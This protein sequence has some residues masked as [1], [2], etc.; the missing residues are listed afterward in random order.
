MNT[1][2]IGAAIIVVARHFDIPRSS[3][4]DHLEMRT[5]SR[6]RG[7]ATV[8]NNNEEWA[9]ESYMLSMVEYG[10]PLTTDQLRLKVALITQERPTP[11]TNGIPWCGWLQ[12]FKNR[13]PV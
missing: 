9:L 13:H 7:L 1:I 12:W 2:E 3:P 11:F 10:H 8:L 6:K 5:R 4:A